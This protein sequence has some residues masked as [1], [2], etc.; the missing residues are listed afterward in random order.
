MNPCGC[1][2]GAGVEPV[3]RFTPENRE[4][5]A[6][7]RPKFCIALAIRVV[8]SLSYRSLYRRQRPEKFSQIVGQEH[9]SRTLSQ[10]LA[11]GR[12]A[13]AYLFCGP[14]GTGKTTAAKILARVL[15][16]DHYPSPEPCGQ[17]RPCQNILAGVSLDVL[18]MDAASNRGID[19]IRDLRERTRYASGE[20]RFKVYIIDEAHMLT[21]EAFNAFLKTLEEPPPGV[22]FVLATT[23]PS[24]LPRTIISRCQ[25]FNF[26]LLNV[27][28]ICRRLEEVAAGEGWKVEPEALTIM[29]YLAEGSMRD[30]LG[31]L[32][33]A[34]PY[35]GELITAEHVRRI[36]GAPRKETMAKLLQSIASNDLAGG[37]SA[38]QEVA[39]GGGDLSLLLKDLT[40]CFSRL[41]LP[42]DGG[43]SRGGKDYSFDRLVD[44]YREK[45][46]R[47]GAME[48]V[49]ILHQVNAE[50][51]QGYSP[52]FTLEIAM[53][54]LL[55]VLHQPGGAPPLE[56]SP[57]VLSEESI[58]GG[59]IPAPAEKKQVL[60]KK[61]Q[62]PSRQEKKQS[63]E[64]LPEKK[65]PEEKQWLALV[66]ERW[67]QL[68]TEV[69]KKQKSTGALLSMA[70]PESQRGNCLL[71][72]F[73]AGQA[74]LRERIM[75][76]AH[77]KTIEEVVSR[78][79]SAPIRIDT[80][81]A[82][83][84]EPEIE[85]VVPGLEQPGSEPAADLIE[86]AA[87]MFNGKV[88]GIEKREG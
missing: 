65:Q 73:K 34:Q 72:S 53:I 87:R 17:C 1:H 13:H 32:E 54:R 12:V 27:D 29:A 77:R 55:R 83:E 42:A 25:R 30:A 48:A 80:I 61:F 8:R 31:F 71:L 49:E 64:K 69:S 88:F 59:P 63:E 70:N 60:A 46:S 4:S 51:R 16:C 9:V 85:E 76:T 78:L 56:N 3:F 66:Q 5:K 68:I 23:D 26:H 21:A 39:S 37:L 57:A 19:E 74:V 33:Q 35:Q 7:A 45:L 84:T 47:R 50:V 14:R 67:A 36:T 44:E 41:L 15:N 40:Y 2:R 52:Q 10:A 79:V 38:L 58:A 86:E 6:G 81:D 11:R 82:R 22:V 18:E 20:G 24:R 62:L 43:S 28:Q 75:E